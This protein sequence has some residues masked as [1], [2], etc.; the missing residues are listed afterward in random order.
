MKRRHLLLNCKLRRPE[1]QTDSRKKEAGKLGGKRRGENLTA[2]Q[3]LAESKLEKMRA[4]R[5]AKKAEL[6]QRNVDILPVEPV[7]VAKTRERLAEKTQSNRASKVKNLNGRQ[8]AS[9]Y[10]QRLSN[11]KFVPKIIPQGKIG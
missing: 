1:I 4:A 7:E 11:G 6:N 5:I 2:K 8:L 9:K 3:R 10:R